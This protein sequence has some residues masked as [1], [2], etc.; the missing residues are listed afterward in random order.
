M[1]AGTASKPTF[2]ILYTTGLRNAPSDNPNDG[3]GMAE[4]VNATIQDRTATVT[5][6]GPAPGF[7]GAD[8]VNLIIPT[9][10]AGAGSVP[11]RL[12]AAGRTSNVVSVRI[13]Q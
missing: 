6:A 4:A 13:G 9:E 1:S 3:N 5:W 10:L 8:Q 7:S 11:I 12:T 2:L